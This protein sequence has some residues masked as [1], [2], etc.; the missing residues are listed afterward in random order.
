MCGL[1]CVR[2]GSA[3]LL[4][5]CG[6][7]GAGAELD[8]VRV[9]NEDRHYGAGRV[10]GRHDVARAGDL[11][12]G[13]AGGGA[14]PPRHVLEPHADGGHHRGGHAG[15]AH[16]RRPVHGRTAARR[17]AD[18]CRSCLADRIEEREKIK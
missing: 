12:V 10:R 6:L 5:S 8:S 4:R 1:G 11:R 15:V 2:V 13:A 7:C 14:A 3:E 16:G 18:L 17:H 9:G